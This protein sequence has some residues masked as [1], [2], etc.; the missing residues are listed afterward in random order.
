[1]GDVR[2]MKINWEGAI[3]KQYL[4]LPKI[5]LFSIRLREIYQK[6]KEQNI[7]ATPACFRCHRRPKNLIKICSFNLS[8]IF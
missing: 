6:E 4:N 1:V 8:A 2:G 7:T 3:D 5:F